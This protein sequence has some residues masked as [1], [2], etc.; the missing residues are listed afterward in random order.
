MTPDDR[1]RILLGSD[2]DVGARVRRHCAGALIE[3]LEQAIALAIREA[4]LDCLN[5]YLA[6]RSRSQGE[7]PGEA[8]RGLGPP[9]PIDGRSIGEQ[10]DGPR[11]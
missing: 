2:T 8:D 9:G 4:N 6:I 10:C 1:A 3:D 5:A 7:I 11:E